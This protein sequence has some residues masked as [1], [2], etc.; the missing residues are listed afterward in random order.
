MSLMSPVPLARTKSLALSCPSTC[1]LMPTTI[2]MVLTDTMLRLHHA[3]SFPSILACCQHCQDKRQQ[4][5]PFLS[6]N[7]PFLRPTW[8][9]LSSAMWSLKLPPASRFLASPA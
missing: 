8:K 2:S 3:R 6:K 7:T 5:Q 1:V 9:A 4:F